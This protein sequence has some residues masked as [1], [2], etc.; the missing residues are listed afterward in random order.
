MSN[1]VLSVPIVSHRTAL[2]SDSASVYLTPNMRKLLSEHGISS[3]ASIPYHATENSI[4]ERGWR[5]IFQL[6]RS[7]LSEANKFSSSITNDFWSHAVEHPTLILNLTCLDHNSSAKFAIENILFKSPQLILEKLLPFGC[8]VFVKVETH[9]AKLDDNSFQALI[10]GYDLT[11]QG[12]KVFNPTTGRTIIT[13]NVLAD[14]SSFYSDEVFS[15]NISSSISEI[16]EEVPLSPLTPVPIMQI[17]Q[18][19]RRRFYL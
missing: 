11:S 4:S 19:V 7:M 18:G 1:S 12:H 15:T 14:L 6:A 9:R 17:M 3:S 8:S 10:I 5:S 2:L 16:D 13:V